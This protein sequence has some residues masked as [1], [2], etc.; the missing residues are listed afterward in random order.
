MVRELSRA[1]TELSLLTSAPAEDLSL[2]S[3][4]A[5]MA[6]A[7]VD[8]GPAVIPHDQQGLPTPAEAGSLTELTRGPQSP[9]IGFPDGSHST[10]VGVSRSDAGRRKIACHPCRFIG[11]FFQKVSKLTL[12]IGA[13][14][15]EGA[16]SLHRAGVFLTDRNGVEDQPT[17]N[18]V[19]DPCVVGVILVTLVAKGSIRLH[20]PAMGRPLG[21]DGTGVSVVCVKLS[22]SE[23]TL[24]GRWDSAGGSA[25]DPDCSS[26]H[27][28]STTS[29]NCRASEG[30]G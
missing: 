16:A 20:T 13:P 26:P 18:R 19:W 1:I 28:W 10:G 24:D 8:P 27:F 12:V 22:E 9:A 29:E 4:S 30:L 6:P 3:D 2:W 5:G 15:E 11:V 23:I 7:S 14:A 21:V 17:P 25:T